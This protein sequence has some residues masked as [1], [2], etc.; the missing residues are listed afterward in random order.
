MRKKMDIMMKKTMAVLLSVTCAAVFTP[1]AAFAGHAEA[2]TGPDA[3]NTAPAASAWVTAGADK[4][5]IGGTVFD[6]SQASKSGASGRWKWQANS[7]YDNTKAVSS[8]NNSGTLT[9]SGYTLSYGRTSYT[10]SLP[11]GAVVRMN[12]K[13]KI[14]NTGHNNVTSAIVADG[15][16]MF[17]GTGSITAVD[18]KSSSGTK[19]SYTCGICI[20]GDI[21]MNDGNLKG[22]SMLQKSTAGNADSDGIVVFGDCT[23]SG[24]AAISGNGAEAADHS[25][26]GWIGGSL[27]I[28][29][30]AVL[31]AMADTAAYS[32]A[33]CVS[34]KMMMN[35]GSL[36]LMS[37]TAA[38]VSR[39]T[40]A[41]GDVSISGG[42]V[43]ILSGDV[44]S[45][46]KS[47]KADAY[48]YGI[49]SDGNISVSGGKLYVTAGTN[50]INSQNAALCGRDIS[51]TG[52][53]TYA[54]CAGGT[55]AA[56]KNS[57][58]LGSG[59]TAKA[60][61]K[62]A[63][64]YD[65]AAAVRDGTIVYTDGTDTVRAKY[66]KL[67]PE[68]ETAG[69]V[70]TNGKYTYKVTTNK[71]EGLFYGGKTAVTGFAPGQSASSV[72]VQ[73]EFD[74]GDYSYYVSSVAAGAFA[75]NESVRKAALPYTIT[76][77]GAK[78]F[79]G[80]RNLRTVRISSTGIRTVGSNAFK[81]INGKAVINVP[82]SKV[83]AY[84]KLFRKAGMPKTVKVY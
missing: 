26:G 84:T 4:V 53:I 38:Q 12:G 3:L 58:T 21:V 61:G 63:G 34:G 29:D 49:E 16:V 62:D 37:G 9:L 65:T 8:T 70:L 11:A 10:V 14:T 20:K 24:R 39:G 72:N 30:D 66:V 27:S 1:A 64:S 51:V 44:S 83:K 80:D 23:L 6:A 57:I 19:S 28:S 52:G 46:A 47:G 69:T 77:I 54:A 33:L 32:D 74:S 42:E 75:G 73:D 81:G 25:Y 13:N 79:C 50:K 76:S 31:L 59:I 67:A 22:K 68:A 82:N 60:A 2:A 71:V 41:A 55:A 78:A 15:D 18:L 40:Y 5:R 17:T 45:A 48:D 36:N 43:S 35:G 56:A 7:G